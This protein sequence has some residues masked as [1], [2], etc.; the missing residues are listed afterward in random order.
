MARVNLVWTG[1][2][3]SWRGADIGSGYKASMQPVDRARR[4]A[5]HCRAFGAFDEGTGRRAGP[6]FSLQRTIRARHV[7]C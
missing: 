3:V 4:Q 5:A 6:W 2:V 7:A 1:A